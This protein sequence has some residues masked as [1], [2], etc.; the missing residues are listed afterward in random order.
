VKALLKLQSSIIVQ[1][2]EHEPVVNKFHAR[3]K[4]LIAIGAVMA[5]A[6]AS[7][8]SAAQSVMTPSAC[9]AV[10]A[11][12]GAIG[13]ATLPKHAAAKAAL[14]AIGAL[15]GAAAG[16]WACSPPPA[17]SSP[18]QPVYEQPQQVHGPQTPVYQQFP[19]PPPQYQRDNDY[20][21]HVVYV[22]GQ[23][24]YRGP[25]MPSS[26]PL[27][28]PVGQAVGSMIDSSPVAAPAQMAGFESAVQR[29]PLSTTERE[30]LDALS[31]DTLDAKAS[32]KSALWKVDQARV[33]GNSATVNGAID[34]ELRARMDFEMKRLNFTKTVNRLHNGVSGEARDV[35]RYMQISGALM[36]LDTESRISYEM[37]QSRDQALQARSQVYAEEVWRSSMK[38]RL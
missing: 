17:A 29:M 3:A 23:G 13:G 31:S 2:A 7:D 21:Q 27:G 5:A 36:E 12:V 8:P 9:A 33:H 6:L 11:T 28:Q 1:S 32:W 19:P 25:S 14:A 30:W 38:R 37:L 26:Q 22:D 24:S 4:T 16:N 35:I 10:G 15:G 34:A 20:G 18:E